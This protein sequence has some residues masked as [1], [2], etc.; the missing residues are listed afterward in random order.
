MHNWQLP[1]AWLLA[2]QCC[3]W[4]CVNVSQSNWRQTA[5]AMHFG[6]STTNSSPAA[7]QLALAAAAAAP[8]SVPGFASDFLYK[9]WYR[10]HA[11]ISSF[12][13]ATDHM[14]RVSASTISPV[15]FEQQFDGPAQPVVLTDAIQGWPMQAWTLPALA[16]AHGASLFEVSKPSGGK[17]LMAL[18]DYLSYMQ[19]Q[20]DEEPLYVFDASFGDRVPALLELYTV[21][22]VF[23]QDL[24]SVLGEWLLQAHSV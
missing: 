23:Q 7:Q 9:R 5:L 14:Q 13:A 11:D 24:L 1:H 6:S 18:G 16:E 2:H 15:K 22:A 4:M 8:P 17:A 20:C 19:R 12:L 10:G 3:T 21:P